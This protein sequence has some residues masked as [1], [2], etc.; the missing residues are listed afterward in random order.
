M[1]QDSTHQEK[2]EYGDKVNSMFDQIRNTGEIIAKGVDLNYRS[3]K[4]VQD[5]LKFDKDD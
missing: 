4:D 1:W 5:N 2:K 3:I